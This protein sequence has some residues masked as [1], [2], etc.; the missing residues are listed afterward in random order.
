[1]KGLTVRTIYRILG[2]GSVAVG[3][4]AVGSVIRPLPRPVWVGG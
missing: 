2:D 1:M 3:S 4:V